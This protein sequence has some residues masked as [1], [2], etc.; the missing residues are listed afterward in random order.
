V[1]IGLTALVLCPVVG[2]GAQR[3]TI[4]DDVDA[5]LRQAATVRVVVAMKA[6]VTGTLSQRR[7]QSSDAQS[8]V[9]AALPAKD[10]Q[11]VRRFTVTPALVGNVTAA[12]LAQLRTDPNVARVDLDRGGT[13]HLSN[14]VPQINVPLIHQDYG[15]DGSGVTVAVLDSGIDTDHPDLVESLAGEQCFCSGNGGCCPSGGS[16]QSGAGAAED[17][18][19]HG[20]HVAGIIT[21][22]GVVAPSGVAPGARIVAVKV[23]DSNNE[24]CCSSDII[25]ALD[26]VANSR[27]DVRVVNMS[28][29]T[30]ATYTGQCDAADATT[31]AFADVIDALT[32]NG[33]AVFAS[34][35]N[36]GLTN[37]T[38]APACVANT[39]SVGAVNI[40]NQ[41]R[42]SSNSDLSLDLLAPGA[43]IVSAGLGGG[44]ATKSGTS[45]ASPHA[46]GTAALLL[47]AFPSL[48]PPQIVAA[49][50]ATGL[51]I[52]DPKS[53]I[54]TP[55]IDAGAAFLSLAPVIDSFKCYLA[56]DLKSP[57]FVQ[58]TVSLSDQL[59]L[60]DGTFALQ[61]PHLICNPADV[62]GAG[63]RHTAPHLVCY[64][65]KGPKISRGD[66]PSVEA[67][68]SFGTAQLRLM[69]P[70]VL[71]V[72]SGKTLLP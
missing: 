56:K 45:M 2:V 65:I 25:A 37:A 44:T 16:T 41:V 58:T 46:A 32:Q 3:Q 31:M 42:S 61:K 36:G 50:Q 33:V 66:R 40:F 9:L 68:D 12:G 43:F 15:V 35:G 4:S 72:P 54:T 8:R 34:S 17:D 30:F 49:L 29:G 60:N 70:F 20:S 38:S 57:K 52:T 11:L 48:T 69:K 26:W 22:D 71:C 14:S 67:E 62:N 53:G 39:V 24:F 55:R 21:N 47:E 13:G 64:K 10:F 27:P 63:I 1:A 5:A 6:A 23:L 51:P 28:L 59:G 18:E 7:R 19:S